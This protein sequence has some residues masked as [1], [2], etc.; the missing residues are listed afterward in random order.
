MT[1]GINVEEFNRQYTAGSAKFHRFHGGKARHI[2][3]QVET[4]LYEE[5]PDAAIILVGGNDLPT[6]KNNPIPVWDIASQITDCAMMCKKY[7]VLDICISSVL[8]RRGP[9]ILQQRRKELNDLL[10]S[11]C[12]LHEFTFIDNDSGEGRFEIDKHIALDGVHLN[13]KGS[14]L[15][16]KKFADVLNDIHNS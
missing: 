11:M 9:H 15:L 3:N 4:H 8:P 12:R 7:G 5:R 14:E 1:K 2:R 13:I 16:A 6:N 10:C